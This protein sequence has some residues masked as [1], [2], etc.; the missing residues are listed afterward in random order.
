[1]TFAPTVLWLHLHPHVRTG[2]ALLRKRTGPTEAAPA[3]MIPLLQ[4]RSY[5]EKSASVENEV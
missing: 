3:D 5:G 2:R 4:S 1:M